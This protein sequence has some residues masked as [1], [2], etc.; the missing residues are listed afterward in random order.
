MAGLSEQAQ[1]EML[2]DAIEDAE[3]GPAMLADL[4]N[5]WSRG[6]LG[7]LEQLIVRDVR[8]EYPELFDVLF[9]QRNLAWAEMLSAEMDGAGVDFVAVGAGHLVGEEGLVELMRARGYDVER[10]TP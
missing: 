4:T 8:D 5:A 3:A 6:E 1:H 9:R 7:A 10:V 2:L